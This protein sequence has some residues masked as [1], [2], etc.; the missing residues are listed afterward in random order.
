MGECCFEMTRVEA[1]KQKMKQVQ[2]GRGGECGKGRGGIM[3]EMRWAN[4][5]VWCGV[6]GRERE[7]RSV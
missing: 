1:W 4:G 2:D 3:T 7:Y 6:R 5:R